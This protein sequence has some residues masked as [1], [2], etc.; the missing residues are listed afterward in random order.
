[1]CFS[2][3]TDVLVKVLWDMQQYAQILF[4]GD[5]HGHTEKIYVKKFMW[6]TLNE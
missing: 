1:M 3:M 4:V 5:G 6:R 2:I